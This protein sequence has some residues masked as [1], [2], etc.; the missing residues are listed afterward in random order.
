MVERDMQPNMDS[1]KPWRC[2]QCHAVLGVVE[3]DGDGFRQ[4]SLRGLWA[5]AGEWCLV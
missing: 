1:V 2:P 4:F 3:R 5:A